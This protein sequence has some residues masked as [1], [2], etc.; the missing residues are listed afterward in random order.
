M[1]N[2]FSQVL[3]KIPPILPVTFINGMNL[4]ETGSIQ[5]IVP[6][7]GTGDLNRFS[8]AERDILLRILQ[9]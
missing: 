6:G 1:G 3:L 5:K 9:I 8:E 2:P 4:V 7:I